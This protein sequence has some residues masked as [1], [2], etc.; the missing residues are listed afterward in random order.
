MAISIQV[1]VQVALLCM[2]TTSMGGIMYLQNA[3]RY[4][5]Q[6]ECA[7]IRNQIT[8]PDKVPK[9]TNKAYSVINVI[10]FTMQY[11]NI[12]KCKS[13]D[14][15]SKGLYFAAQ[16]SDLSEYSYLF[17]IGVGLDRSTRCIKP[18]SP[19]GQ[20]HVHKSH[21]PCIKGEI[22]KSMKDEDIH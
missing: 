22:E 4:W 3:F 16:C 15:T 17:I 7:T 18:L 12:Q 5:K 19:F 13:F 14:S 2:E 11:V 1:F 8:S 20:G 6:S 21:Y 10:N 9:M